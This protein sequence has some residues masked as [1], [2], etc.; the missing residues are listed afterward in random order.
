MLTG[1]LRPEETSLIGQW[2]VID[3]EVVADETTL[4]I[5]MLTEH[6]LEK[7][8]YGP[9]GAWETLYIDPKDRRYWEKTYLQ[10]DLH[11]GGPPSLICLSAEAAKN[12]YPEAFT[13]E[14]IDG[15]DR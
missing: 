15:N 6:F 5:N 12:K 1:M 14:S 3:N 7:M 11:G 4:R 2:L 10:S 13:A 8:G 9:Y